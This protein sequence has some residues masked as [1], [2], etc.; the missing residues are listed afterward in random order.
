MDI[1]AEIARA[2]QDGRAALD[3][4]AGKG[5]LES[6]GVAVPRT[7]VAAGPDDAAAALDG[8]AMPVVVKV[9]SPEILHKSDA[10]GVA[11]NLASADA[12]LGVIQPAV[13]L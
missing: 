9:M 8:L 2:R 13:V 6:C 11:I 4:R 10:G 3:E 5:I 7:A 1:G 12:A